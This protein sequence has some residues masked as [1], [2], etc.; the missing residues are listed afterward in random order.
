MFKTPRS[1]LRPSSLRGGHSA[2]GR[3]S[4]VRPPASGQERAN[5]LD[6][7]NEISK[8][9]HLH[10]ERKSRPGPITPSSGGPTRLNM[11]LLQTPVA[12]SPST[13]SAS[14][15]SA[16]QQ[17]SGDDPKLL[18]YL[19]NLRT[20]P[21]TSHNKAD[22]KKLDKVLDNLLGAIPVLKVTTAP[23][24]DTATAATQS[25][26]HNF[27]EWS[28]ALFE[29]LEILCNPLKL[30][31]ESLHSVDMEVTTHNKLQ[32]PPLPVDVHTMDRVQA[33]TAIKQTVKPGSFPHLI[34]GCGH[35]DVE[36]A[37]FSILKE[38]QP[39][40]RL[41]RIKMRG[42]FFRNEID[43]TVENARMFSDRLLKEA[44]KLNMILGPEYS[45]RDAEVADTF[46]CGLSK[47]ERYD[48]AVTGMKTDCSMRLADMVA[49][50]TQNTKEPLLPS[51]LPPPPQ[52]N[53]TR[54]NWRPN[55]RGRGGG[56]GRGG[57]RGSVSAEG[58]Q[59]A[60]D[61]AGAPRD[62]SKEPCIKNLLGKCTGLNAVCPNGRI[63]SIPTHLLQQAQQQPQQQLQQQLQQ[64]PVHEY[65]QQ[66]Q[67]QL[68]HTPHQRAHAVQQQ[69]PIATG[70][71]PQQTQLEQ[72]QQ[73]QRQLHQWEQDS[74]GPPSSQFFARTTITRDMPSEGFAFGTSY[75]PRAYSRS[76]RLYDDGFKL[77]A[78][79]A[80]FSD[81]PRTT[82]PLTRT[83][84]EDAR[85]RT[86]ETGEADARGDTPAHTQR[87]KETQRKG[88]R[89]TQRDT[90][91]D[92]E[93]QKYIETQGLFFGLLFSVFLS[94]LTFIFVKPLACLCRRLNRPVRSRCTPPTGHL[95][96]A[97]PLATHQ[98]AA[99][100]FI[101]LPV[102]LS[103]SSLGLAFL[104]IF[105][106]V[107]SCLLWLPRKLFGAQRPHKLKGM[108]VRS[109]RK[110]RGDKTNRPKLNRNVMWDDGCNI[111][112]SNKKSDFVGPL[113]PYNVS[114]GLAD[115]NLS[116]QV[117]H[118]GQILLQN[119]LVDALY[120][121]TLNKTLVSGGWLLKEMGYLP[122]DS[123]SGHKDIVDRK[124][125]VWMSFFLAED[126][127]YYLV[128]EHTLVA[129][130]A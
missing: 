39:N 77:K 44:N 85:M 90:E 60:Q 99:V 94:L 126:N 63:H 45:I 103:L 127:L 47:A 62:V 61:Q 73:Q 112:V 65:K 2:R 56:K 93:R 76:D 84:T 115:A 130:S 116:S 5:L 35:G 52:A 57:G 105:S 55:S 64:Q 14:L 9:L 117:T 74:H 41:A 88:H 20:Q 21:N 100:N 18:A 118:K 121:P 104:F 124:G 27:S 113:V 96:R 53:S 86:E 79:C 48:K 30:Y 91:K 106:R 125:N 6:N 110:F 26:M 25:P 81:P 1:S 4:T 22:L 33:M 109:G 72:H 19:N 28:N 36:Q 120:S 71:Q 66:S 34:T 38:L 29:Y 75:E 67:V 83:C 54:G 10:T 80:I 70:H 89:K 46:I 23:S 107:S 15:S 13:S 49:F 128:E 59:G 69:V 87:E 43:L 68:Q 95:I 12:T 101:S 8:R 40:L 24:T 92:T 58:T 129:S 11:K 119:K 122:R 7:Y 3:S 114:L 17:T 108:A 78:N 111:I 32:L 16:R 31:L 123:W 98:A 51:S 102:R 37:Y 50:V 82:D 42:A 97:P